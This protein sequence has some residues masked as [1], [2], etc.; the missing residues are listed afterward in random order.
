[1][2]RH[3]LHRREKA[4]SVLRLKVL[5]QVERDDGVERAWTKVLGDG[6]RVQLDVLVVDPERAAVLERRTMEVHADEVPGPAPEPQ[7]R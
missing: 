5:D 4:L 7:Q 1:M 3:S 2:A 6:E